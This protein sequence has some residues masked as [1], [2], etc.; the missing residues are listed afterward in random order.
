MLLL[1]TSTVSVGDFIG[2]GTVQENTSG[3]ET[4]DRRA[5]PL[6]L[7]YRTEGSGS[8]GENEE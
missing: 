5:I 3:L 4:C 1:L 7:L 6:P 8:G 2:S